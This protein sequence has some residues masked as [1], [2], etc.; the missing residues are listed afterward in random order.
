VVSASVLLLW[1]DIMGRQGL[2]GCNKHTET[3]VKAW[4]K[5]LFLSHCHFHARHRFLFRRIGRYAL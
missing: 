5:G 1:L 2:A 4:E 3:L